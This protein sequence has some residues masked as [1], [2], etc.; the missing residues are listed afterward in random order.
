MITF[1]VF[2]RPLYLAKNFFLEAGKNV[3]VEKEL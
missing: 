1:N 2:H 3:N